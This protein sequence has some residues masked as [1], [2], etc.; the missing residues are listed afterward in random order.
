MESVDLL[1]ACRHRFRCL[2]A[3][4]VLELRF[5]ETAVAPGM[6]NNPSPYHDRLHLPRRADV[7]QVRNGGNSIGNMWPGQRRVPKQDQIS[8]SSRAESSDPITETGR[9]AARHGCHSQNLLGRKYRS[10]EARL[11]LQ[12][13]AQTHFDKRILFPAKRRVVASERHPD[14]PFPHP[15][16]GG[17]AALQPQVRARIVTDCLPHG[18]RNRPGRHPRSI[19][20]A[21]RRRWAPAHRAHRVP[22]PTTARTSDARQP[23]D[24]EFPARACAPPPPSSSASRR[25][26]CSSSKVTHCGATGPWRIRMLGVPFPLS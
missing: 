12:V 6:I 4:L 21:P 5:V 7:E 10:V 24:R 8:S 13:G 25:Q 14:T 3:K 9:H 17:D 11:P 15:Q 1:L 2:K 18:P 22:P 20:R 16:D 23:T 19:R 26:R